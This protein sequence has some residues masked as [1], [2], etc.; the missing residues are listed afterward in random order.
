[1]CDCYSA[2]CE[3]CGVWIAVH[4]GD[5]CVPRHALRVWCPTCLRSL[6][7]M[8]LF[9]WRGS[10]G[11]PDDA[12]EDKPYRLVT[13]PPILLTADLVEESG[14]VSEMGQKGDAVLFAVDDPFPHGI[15]LN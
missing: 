2:E 11:R 5:F 8:D 6:T 14:Q 10:L 13:H 3:G 12:V 4:I 7:V 1:M 9:K 15:N